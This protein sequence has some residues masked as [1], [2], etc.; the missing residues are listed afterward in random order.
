MKQHAKKI[1]RL[2]AGWGLMVMAIIGWLLPVIPG[3]F[4]FIMGV[5]IL[6]IPFFHRQIFWL[7]NQFPK[8]AQKPAFR[9][10]Q[11]K[12]LP[13]KKSNNGGQNPLK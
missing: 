8:L 4:F 9:R 10:W 11:Q 6:D 2:S 1:L 5:L 13:C 3:W 12:N 7:L